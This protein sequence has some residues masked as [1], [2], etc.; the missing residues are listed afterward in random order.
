[1]EL[2]GTAARLT[3]AAIPFTPS[4]SGQRR[5]GSPA[6]GTPFAQRVEPGD[7]REGSRGDGMHKL[8]LVLSGQVDVEGGSGGWLVLP[9]HLILIPAERPF[10]LRTVDGTVADVAHLDPADAP[11]RHEGCW[12]TCAG[13]LAQEMMSY[14][15]R[16]DPDREG[17]RQVFRALSHMCGEWFANPR[18]LFVPAARSVEMR[19]V[20]SYV[21]DHLAD[22]TVRGACVAAG[23]PQ[24]TLHRRCHQEFGFGLRTL[25]RETRLMQAMEMLSRSD[26]PVQV[27]ARTVGFASVP[28]FT[29]AFTARLA[30][31][32][33][34]YMRHSRRARSMLL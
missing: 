23:M 19:A 32:P 34:D 22:A 33:S 20:I 10:N 29:S 25:I 11:W 1:M 17:A 7:W 6:S 30:A 4:A 9:G 12:V 21:R 14:V 8:I 15:R 28:S 3:R 27:V 16:L 31:A 24:R 2:T 13:P 18:M 26:V 5:F